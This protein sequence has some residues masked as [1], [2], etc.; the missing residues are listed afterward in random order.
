MADFSG[1]FGPRA[2]PDR[3]TFVLLWT[4]ALSGGCTGGGGTTSPHDSGAATDAACAKVVERQVGVAWDTGFDGGNIG[5]AA[6]VFGQLCQ[7]DGGT[8]PCG[9]M[10]AEAGTVPRDADFGFSAT[11]STGHFTSDHC[12]ADATAGGTSGVCMWEQYASFFRTR[13]LAG[14]DEQ[15]FCAGQPAAAYVSLVGTDLL[16][17]LQSPDIP[18]NATP[19]RGTVAPD[20][21]IAFERPDPRSLGF[22]G[23]GTVDRTNGVIQIVSAGGQRWTIRTSDCPPSLRLSP[24]LCLAAE[25]CA[26]EGHAVGPAERAKGQECCPG[27]EERTSVVPTAEGQCGMEGEPGTVT[28]TRCNDGKCGPGENVCNCPN[29]CPPADASASQ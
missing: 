17:V 14:A 24:E 8:V 13:P 25:G 28:W 4:L 20:G 21:T 9:A 5:W 7:L 15:R 11:S 16:A 12:L 27:L 10:L 29:D 3:D 18:S 22:T 19:A 6:V 2:R 1:M 23:G 26:T